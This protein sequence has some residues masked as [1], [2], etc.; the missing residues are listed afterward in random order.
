M[1]ASAN[2]VPLYPLLEA[3]LRQR[4]LQL[5]PIYKIGDAAS[6]FGVSPR[7]VHDW[8]ADGRLCA[9]DLP[10]RGRFL[11]QDLESL[12]AASFK[13]RE[14]PNS[15]PQPENGRPRRKPRK[16]RPI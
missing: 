11:P 1:T 10:G 9:R 12:L 4:G 15:E 13:K 7:T 5:L 8:I 6:V 2:E 3:L 16:Q 14:D